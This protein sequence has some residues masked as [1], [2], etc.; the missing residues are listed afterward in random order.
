MSQILCICI[1]KSNKHFPK[2]KVSITENVYLTLDLLNGSKVSFIC[3]IH[4]SAIKTV[5]KI[6]TSNGI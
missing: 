2:N 4:S 5:Y 6:S 3:P 1:P